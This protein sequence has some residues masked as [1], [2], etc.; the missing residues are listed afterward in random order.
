MENE[1]VKRLVWSGLVAGLGVLASI[2][3]QRTAGVIWRRV[4]GEEPPE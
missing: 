1:L 3:A 2:A 4:F